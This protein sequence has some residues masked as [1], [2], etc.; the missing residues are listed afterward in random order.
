MIAPH[1]QLALRWATAPTNAGA[2]LY[3][4]RK[5]ATVTA[6]HVMDF[7]L[8]ATAV[9]ESCAEIG[10]TRAHRAGLLART[11]Y[12]YARHFSAFACSHQAGLSPFCSQCFRHRADHD[13]Q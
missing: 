8:L 6:F 5:N 2:V 10:L 9:P 13:L 7:S 4:V 1:D 12:V 3:P 11:S